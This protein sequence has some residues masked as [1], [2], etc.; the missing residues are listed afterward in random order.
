ML[1]KYR[2]VHEC[3]K[4]VKWREEKTDAEINSA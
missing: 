4:L 1:K 2:D 3:Q